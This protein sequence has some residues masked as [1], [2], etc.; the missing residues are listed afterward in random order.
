MK[1]PHAEMRR[2]AHYPRLMLR[3]RVRVRIPSGGLY[4]YKR[5]YDKIAYSLTWEYDKMRQINWML[6]KDLIGMS[7]EDKN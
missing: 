2:E 6:Q 7:A 4:F 5:D 1:F 3:K